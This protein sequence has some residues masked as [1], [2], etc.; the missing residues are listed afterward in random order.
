MLEAKYYSLARTAMG[1]G[2]EPWHL[3]DGKREAR[4][5]FFAKHHMYP[6]LDLIAKRKVLWVAHVLRGNE[7]WMQSR[8]QSSR[9]EQ[10]KWWVAFIEDLEK[11]CGITWEKVEELYK[12]PGELKNL[13]E[14]NYRI[15]IG[16]KG[17]RRLRKLREQVRRA[18]TL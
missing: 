4:I 9:E 12:K 15:R 2:D 18:S 17:E 16:T 6:V 11:H 13:I 7:K 14:K 8:L 3:R 10:D 5:E 1:E